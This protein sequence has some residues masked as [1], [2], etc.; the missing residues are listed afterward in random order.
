VCWIQLT[1]VWY[2]PRVWSKTNRRALLKCYNQV[3]EQKYW[4]YSMTLFCL[5]YEEC[6]GAAVE[7]TVLERKVSGSIRGENHTSVHTFLMK[8]VGKNKFLPIKDKPKTS[9]MFSWSRTLI[10]LSGVHS[11]WLLCCCCLPTIK[12][13]W[14]WFKIVYQ[15]VTS[16]RGVRNIKIERHPVRSCLWTVLHVSLTYFTTMKASNADKFDIFWQQLG[17]WVS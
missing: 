3:F 17:T 1:A 11:L 8:S 7:R 14:L 4:L 6:L 2:K 9:Y 13:E 15:G 10:F 5:K 12:L 16:A